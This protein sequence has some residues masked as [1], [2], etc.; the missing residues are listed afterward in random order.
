MFSLGKD[1]K[2]PAVS[3]SHGGLLCDK[4]T[5]VVTGDILA[6]GTFFQDTDFWNKCQEKRNDVSVGTK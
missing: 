3:F 6:S 1:L 2:S 5:R 4:I